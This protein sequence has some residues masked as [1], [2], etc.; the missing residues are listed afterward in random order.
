MYN[1]LNLLFTP[2]CTQCD[3]VGNILC[4]RCISKLKVI[5][6][7]KCIICQQPATN[8]FTHK[9]CLTSARPPQLISY[10]EY[11]GSLQKIIKQAKYSSKQFAALKEVAKITATRLATENYDFNGFTGIPIPLSNHKYK[12]RGFNQAELIAKIV[13]GKINIA[14][15]LKLLIRAVDT[16]PQYKNTR[17]ERFKNLKDAFGV[18]NSSKV[19]GNR[20][21]LIDDIS[22]SGATFLEAS[23][24]LYNAGAKDVKCFALCKRD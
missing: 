4:N 5:N 23:R 16:L 15:N 1:F 22:T 2:K 20:F 9:A 11:S 14:V 8:G 13:C 19:V 18:K 3:A 24:V 12:E 10:Y 17:L 6:I 7:Q 21:L